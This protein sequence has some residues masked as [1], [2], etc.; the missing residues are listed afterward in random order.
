M[1]VLCLTCGAA[2]TYFSLAGSQKR[3]WCAQHSP[4][5]AVS[6]RTGLPTSTPHGARMAAAAAQG[7]CPLAKCPHGAGWTGPL[8]TPRHA[9]RGACRACVQLGRLHWR[10]GC[11]GTCKGQRCLGFQDLFASGPA[12]QAYL[13]GEMMM[14]GRKR[15]APPSEV[16]PPPKRLAL[17]KPAAGGAAADGCS[18][19]QTAGVRRCTSGPWLWCKSCSS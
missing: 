6:R 16:A 17:P 15:S 1:G 14:A 4:A 9:A 18:M 2:A 13:A 12:W 7:R 19:C 5:G 3:W 8:V 11:G 10:K